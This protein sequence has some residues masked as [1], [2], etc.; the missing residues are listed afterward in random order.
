MSTGGVEQLGRWKEQPEGMLWLDIQSESLSDSRVSKLLEEMNCH[1]LAILDAL[2][3]RHPPKVELFEDHFFILYRG[4]SEVRSHINFD[5][6]QIAF[7]VGK[8]YLI[9]LHPRTSLGIEK[10][11]AR[12]WDNLKKFSPMTLALSIIHYSAGIY[13]E[14]ILSFEDE[15]ADIEEVLYSERSEAALL[16]LASY[17]ASLI[18]LKRVFN[19]HDAMFRQFKHWDND[20][21][22]MDC[23]P[24]LHRINDVAERLERIHSLTQMYYDICGDMIDSY[25]S[26]TSHQMNITMRVL[27]VVTVIFVPLTFIAGIYG[28]NFENIPELH[29]RYGYFIVVAVMLFMSITMVM[30]FKKKKWF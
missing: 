23:A 10:E 18:K 26:I 7:F 29:Y 16:D 6:Q 12:G 27:T 21:L 19:Y 14:Q 17:K 24:F 28:M 4:M 11:L 20:E 25:I 8:N 1:P 9:T 5:H 22:P 30:I 13:L 2:R 3:K 15:L